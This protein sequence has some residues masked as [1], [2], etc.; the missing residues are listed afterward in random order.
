[1]GRLENLRKRFQKKDEKPQNEIINEVTSLASFMDKDAE[2]VDPDALQHQADGFHTASAM[3]DTIF[4]LCRLLSKKT[5]D[6]KFECDVWIK[7][8]KS[9]VSMSD[10]RLM[11]SS[12]S[13]YIFGKTEEELTTFET[14]M[15]SV[16]HYMESK[17]ME[18]QEDEELRKTYK[19]VL[20]FYDHSNLAIQQQKLV[21]KKRGDLED[22]VAKIVTPKISE[23]TK[24]MTAQLVG[25]IG[26]FTA[27]SFVVFGGIS[28]LDSIFGAVQETMENQHTVLPVLILA[29]AWALCMM[30]LL[31]GFMYFIIRITH[32]KKLTDENAKNLVQRYPVV[33]LCNYILLALLVLFSG[34]W[35]AKTTGVGSGIYNTW[36]NNN[37]DMTFKWAVLIFIAVF[38]AAGIALLAMYRSN[39]NE[40]IK[41]WLFTKC[42]QN[43]LRKSSIEQKDKTL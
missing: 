28:S 35:F 18:K 37:P 10:G 32:L 29:I 12:I 11:Y 39:K 16:L 26:I 24:E 25:M 42:L 9:Y 27:L 17:V 34:M 36:V 15:D 8:L 21:S 19:S 14:N 41:Y 2:H 31:F 4:V 13:N 7:Q 22:E 38:V 5:S 3:Q 23:I 40:R 1:M 30:N 20:K 43:Y 6:G 33:F